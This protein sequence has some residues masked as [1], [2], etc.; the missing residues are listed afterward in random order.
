M[1]ERAKDADK[2]E[3]HARP[4]RDMFF[5]SAV[6]AGGFASV[7]L[8]LAAMFASSPVPYLAGLLP[9]GVFVFASRDYYGRSFPSPR[10]EVED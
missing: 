4:Q 9:L 8:T 2:V 3:R 10:Q 7:S 1:S 5:L 6:I